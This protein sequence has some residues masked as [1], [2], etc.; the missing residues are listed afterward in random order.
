MGGGGTSPLHDVRVL[1]ARVASLVELQESKDAEIAALRAKL[2][3][4]AAMR[5]RSDDD[6]AAAAVASTEGDGLTEAG[7]MLEEGEAAP[8]SEATTAD[9]S[10]VTSS[11]AFFESLTRYRDARQRLLMNS[12][13]T[14]AWA[15]ACFETVCMYGLLDVAALV[16]ARG[17]S[18]AWREAVDKALRHLQNLAFPSNTTGVDVLTMLM[19]VAGANLKMVCLEGCLQLIADDM[20]AI[21]VCAAQVCPAVVE[22]KLAGC[23]KEA[24]LRALAAAAKRQFGAGSPADLHAMLL[25]L[26]EADSRCPLALLLGQITSPALC[27]VGEGGHFAPGREAFRE[28]VECAI[29]DKAVVYVVALLM[30]CAFNAGGDGEAATFDCNADLSGSRRTLRGK[31][32]LHLV[33]EGGGPLELLLLLLVAGARVDAKDDVCVCVCVC[34]R[35]C[36]CVR[37]RASVC[38]QSTVE[39]DVRV[40]GVS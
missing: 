37:V 31:R 12:S 24:I 36:V 33:A 18:R 27:V 34:V 5:E 40:S 23:R 1:Q 35:A 38:I 20:E 10:N 25:A 30:A 8:P 13:F 6:V 39:G 29:K 32:A 21:L 11:V 22:V 17:V 2:S 16:R 14:A 7:K 4:R 19:R 15:E 26:A 3:Q 28:A 9:G